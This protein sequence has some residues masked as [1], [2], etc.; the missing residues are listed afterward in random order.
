[1][2]KGHDL[3]FLPWKNP[4]SEY[5]NPKQIPIKANSKFETI[6]RGRGTKWTASLLRIPLLRNAYR[7][8]RTDRQD[9]FESRAS[10]FG[11]KTDVAIAKE[12]IL[13]QAVEKKPRVLGIY[14]TTG[15][16]HKAI[17]VASEVKKYWGIK[18]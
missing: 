14:C 13:T 5:R 10:C 18:S 3:E 15:F 17:A 6:Q 9:G 12:D 4:K 2:P 11:F 8:R 16:H 1:V 7:G